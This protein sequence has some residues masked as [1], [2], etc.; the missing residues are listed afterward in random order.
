MTLEL[1]IGR[2]YKLY[3][4]CQDA[5]T[6]EQM[7]ASLKKMEELADKQIKKMEKE[8][9]EQEEQEKFEKML[10]FVLK[11]FIAFNSNGKI[12]DYQI[13]WNKMKKYDE[14]NYSKLEKII[15][16]LIYLKI[17][18]K[19]LFSVFMVCN[20]TLDGE[21]HTIINH[22]QEDIIE[23]YTYK[24]PK[25]LDILKQELPKILTPDVFDGEK[26]IV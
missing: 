5:E 11:V 1:V 16:D 13:D 6:K 24:V 14:Q 12:D 20:Q 22:N 17:Y 15:Y 10:Q 26:L 2:L 9:R 23:N 21:F 19:P 4:D 18:N 3:K 8:E 25:Y 7:L